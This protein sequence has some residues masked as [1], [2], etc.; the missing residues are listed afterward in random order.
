MAPLS[1]VELGEWHYSVC[2]TAFKLVSLRLQDFQI[3]LI[4]WKQF[5]LLHNG[6]NQS[7]QTLNHLIR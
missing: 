7:F 5:W 1:R 3:S 4:F 6:G 2:L